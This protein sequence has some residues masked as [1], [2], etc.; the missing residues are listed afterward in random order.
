M[1]TQVFE[2]SCILLRQ[3]SKKS[4]KKYNSVTLL[5]KETLNVSFPVRVF[6]F[7]VLETGSCYQLGLA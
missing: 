3:T 6:V 1:Q 7:V 2:L 5:T 4:A